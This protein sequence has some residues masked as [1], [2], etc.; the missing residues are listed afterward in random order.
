M[1]RKNIKRH[2]DFPVRK[3][4]RFASRFTLIELLIVIAIIAILA[5]ML[6]PA[7]QKARERARAISCTSNFN[8]LSKI[9][10]F[11]YSDYGNFAPWGKYSSACIYTFS[12]TSSPLK[13]YFPKDECSIFGGITKN[14]SGIKRSKMLC[15]SVDIGDIDVEKGG[16]ICNFPL[17]KGSMY[18]S[19]A[20]NMNL[21]NSY[22]TQPVKISNVKSPSRLV[23]YVDSCGSGYSDSYYCRWFAGIS[24][25]EHMRTISARHSGSANFNY[26]DGHVSSVKRESF[27]SSKYNPTLYPYSGPD[28]NPFAK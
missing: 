10:A 5:G 1:K 22:G 16:N 9:N 21:I 15:P 3:L 7:L 26:L 19:I 12:F 20:A 2:W 24:S 8:Q 23:F 13:D 25:P 17:S 14:S 4:N 6:L 11:Y 18:C 27:P 28:W